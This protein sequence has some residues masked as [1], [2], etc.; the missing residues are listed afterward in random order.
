MTTTS[1]AEE[2]LPRD[3]QERIDYDRARCRLGLHQF[4]RAAWSQIVADRFVD[5]PHLRVLCKR[6]EAVTSGETRR[7]VINVPPG[8]SKSLVV[9]VFWPA[10][11]WIEK[12]PR[13]RWIHASYGTDLARR[14]AVRTRTLIESPWYQERWGISIPYQNTR[15]AMNYE[16]SSGGQRI[17]STVGG[18]IT[19]Q[20]ADTVV[21]DDPIKPSEAHVGRVEMDRVWEWWTQTVPTRLKDPERGRKVI[22]MQRLHE[23]DLAG[24]CLDTGLYEHL[25]LPMRF[26]ETNACADDWRTEPGELLC[27]ARFSE[28]S[29]AGLEAE[30]GS[31]HAAAQLQQRPSPQEGGI[32]KAGWLDTTWSRRPLEGDG[33]WVQSWDCAFKGKQTSDFVVGTIWCATREGEYVL[34]DLVRGRW[35]FTETLD[36]IRALSS[37]FPYAKTKLVEDAANGAAIVDTLTAEVDGLTLVRP[38]GGK[39][40]RAHAV[41]HL[42]RSGQVVLPEYAPWLSEYRAEMTVFPNAL[43]DDQV[44]STT[45]ALLFLAAAR[46]VTFSDAMR[47][48]RAELHGMRKAG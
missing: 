30:M 21:V 31:Q 35:S 24:R 15:S 44:D 4:I 29:V 8:T 14:D 39:E 11:V 46:D 41:S 10:W 22:I 26:D 18:G 9:S 32:F 36:Q 43:H 12:D 7:L 45:Q 6:L 13:H 20:H 23:A 47:A 37:R 48:A 42:L 25:C 28:E 27:P 38:E 16:V 2:L 17:T 3:H 1:R 5:G 33:R 34:V 19:G 40:A